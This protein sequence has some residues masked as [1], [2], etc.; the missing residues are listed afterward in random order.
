VNGNPAVVAYFQAQTQQGIISGMAAF[1]EHRG[2]TYQVIAYAPAQTFGRYEQAFRQVIF[3]FDEMNDP[4]V[5]NIRPN[6]VD[7]VRTTRQM[8]L[9]EFNRQNPSVIPL[10]ELAILN[11]VENEN[12]LL[13]AGHWKRVVAQ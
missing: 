2:Q 8:T 11:Q 4:A 12:S 1:I 3:S 10:P 7:V 5:I 6:R 9:A 13:P